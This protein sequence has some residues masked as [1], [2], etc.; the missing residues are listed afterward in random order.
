MAADE[1]MRLEAGEDAGEEAPQEGWDGMVGPLNATKPVAFATGLVPL[2]AREEAG[3]AWLGMNDF[4]DYQWSG[5]VRRALEGREKRAA[6][7]EASESE[8]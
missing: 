4:L 2:A 1:K 5:G 7:A 6:E 8:E 3:E